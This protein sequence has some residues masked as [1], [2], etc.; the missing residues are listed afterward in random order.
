MS[1]IVIDTNVLLVADG[2]GT[3]MGDACRVVCMERLDRVKTSEQV[4]LDDRWFVLGEYHNRLSPHG[5]PTPGNAFLKWLL[6]VQGDSSHVELVTI[7]PTNAEQTT[8]AEFPPDAALE[9]AFDPADRKFVATANA[10]P[11]K[12]PIL[13]SADSKWLGWEDQLKKH[14]I[15]VEVLCRGELKA[16]R[17]RKTK[18]KR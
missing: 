17:E 10:H 13:E 2:K 1:G 7:T 3:H 12:P 14:G 15:K 9:A 4:I 6:Q 11:E 16:I 5:R 8:F 18:K